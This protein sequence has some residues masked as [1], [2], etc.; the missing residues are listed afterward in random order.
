MTQAK[1][2]L[3]RELVGCSQDFWRGHGG[4]LEA[5]SSFSSWEGSEQAPTHPPSLL[6]GGGQFIAIIHVAFVKFSVT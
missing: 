2:A 4:D 5:A 1:A 3:R 6:K